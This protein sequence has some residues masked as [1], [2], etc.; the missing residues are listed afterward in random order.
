MKKLLSLIISIVLVLTLAVPAAAENS[1]DLFL[2]NRG[3]PSHLIMKM[4]DVQKQI[5]YDKIH[6]NPNS[7]FDFYEEEY[8]GFSEDGISTYASNIPTSE[9]RFEVVGFNDGNNIF[10]VFPSFYWLNSNN[11]T[12][13]D[14]FAYAFNSNYWEITDTP[15]LVLYMRGVKPNGDDEFVTYDRPTEMNF[16]GAGFRLDGAYDWD[17]E[18]HG[19]V[20]LRK[21]SSSATRKILMKYID[22]TAYLS[23]N[24]GIDIGVFNINFTNKP[25]NYRETE[26]QLNF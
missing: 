7:Y 18:A 4:S 2:E 23:P 14:V 25:W 1:M 15:R 26:Q 24:I 11:K 16:A 22:Y 20:T 13:H 10:S 9:L 17:Y 3:V 12:N 5:I 6:S 19:T 21:I 8:I